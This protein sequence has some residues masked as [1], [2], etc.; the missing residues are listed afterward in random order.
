[1]V[2]LQKALVHGCSF[3]QLEKIP[4]GLDRK[5]FAF[6]NE[7]LKL[8]S[9]NAHQLDSGSNSQSYNCVYLPIP[10]PYNTLSMIFENIFKPIFSNQ[11][12]TRML[13]C[14]CQSKYIHVT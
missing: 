13:T 12:F 7:Y 9:G 14:S 11:T 5:K 1:M 3:E 10:L 8:Q 2:S 6:R 4:V